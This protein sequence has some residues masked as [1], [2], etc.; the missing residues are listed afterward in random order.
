LSSP[1]VDFV[2]S[3]QVWP[4]ASPGLGFQGRGAF[5][6]SADSKTLWSA[7]QERMRPSGWALG[8]AR[9]LRIE[10][11]MVRE[12][13]ELKHPAGQLDSLLWAE[14]GRA[15]A[16]FGL[17]GNRYRP[18][19][20]NSNPTLALVD[21]VNGRVLDSL[22]FAAIGSAVGAQVAIDSIYA[23]EVTAL[24]DGRMQAF[25]SV[26]MPDGSS[27]WIVWTQGEPPRVLPNPYSGEKISAA[28][29]SD[30]NRLLIV[31][32]NLQMVGSCP[33]IPGRGCEA[34]GPPVE[35]VLTAMHDLQSGSTMWSRRER[36][37]TLV[38]RYPVP[39]LSDDGRYGLIALPN[40]GPDRS[41]SIA[42]IS[43][44][45]GSVEHVSY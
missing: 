40:A 1:T 33:D 19:I 24:S 45:D 35:G 11:G 37:T 12:L 36:I 29:S 16:L 26:I 4:L 20:A 25:L 10:D 41:Y 27:F 30:G 18:Q 9:P 15:L 28:M 22:T 31:R 8:P 5:R 13:P 32:Q 6:W 39:A 42:L 34:V 7:D 3:H 38:G 21:A 2:F 23:A 17:Q 14:G 43:T 44:R